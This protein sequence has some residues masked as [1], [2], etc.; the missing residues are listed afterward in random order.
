MRNMK[1]NILILLACI[2][3]NPFAPIQAQEQ[4]KKFMLQSKFRNMYLYIKDRQ[5]VA[6]DKYY[7]TEF[8]INNGELIKAF[9]PKNGFYEVIQLR[10]NQFILD[11]PPSLS[12]EEYQLLRTEQMSDVPPSKSKV[13]LPV[14]KTTWY[15]KLS[16]EE[17]YV[18]LVCPYEPYLNKVLSITEQIDDYFFKVELVPQKNALDYDQKWQFV[19]IP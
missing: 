6:T 9:D 19:E 1:K 17:K 3:M 18:Y 2:L 13:K 16:D 15:F 5:M 7:G 11:A 12:Q 4:G 10:D 14:I 8:F